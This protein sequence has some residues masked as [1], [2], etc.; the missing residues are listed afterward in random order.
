MRGECSAGGIETFEKFFRV[1]VTVWFFKRVL[2]N[3]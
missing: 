2:E 1:S 3:E